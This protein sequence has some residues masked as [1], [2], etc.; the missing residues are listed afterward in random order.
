MKYF[1]VILFAALASSFANA[2]IKTAVKY[3]ADKILQDKGSDIV[4]LIGN[5]QI[6]K[7]DKIMKAAKIRLNLT[8]GIA[9]ASGQANFTAEDM[10]INL[11]TGTTDKQ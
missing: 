4:E 7:G 6:S 11:K 2:Q 5:A 8:T 1:V 3:S 9:T 10:T